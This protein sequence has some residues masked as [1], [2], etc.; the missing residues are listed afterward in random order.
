[1]EVI[2]ERTAGFYYCWLPSKPDLCFLKDLC[3]Y[4]SARCLCKC[5]LLRSLLLSLS[6]P[7][8]HQTKNIQQQD[9]GKRWGGRVTM[10]KTLRTTFCNQITSRFSSRLAHFF[11]WLSAI[12]PCRKELLL[13]SAQVH[14]KAPKENSQWTQG[15]NKLKCGLLFKKITQP[16][17]NSLLVIN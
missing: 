14:R 2:T 15:I 4:F 6:F 3:L 16:M 5:V 12:P 9:K 7:A 11:L 10:K 8:F 13:C 17:W 1:M